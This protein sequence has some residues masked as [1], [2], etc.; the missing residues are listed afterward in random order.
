MTHRAVW[1]Q[2]AAVLAGVAIVAV[3]GLRLLLTPASGTVLVLL[4]ARQP[5]HV[6]GVPVE[7]HSS[8][9]WVGLGRISD[10]SVPA[11]PETAQVAQASVPAAEYDA[12]R[13]GGEVLPARFRV[14]RGLVAPILVTI[15]SGRP[16]PAGIYAGSEGVSLGLNELAGQLRAVPAFNLV[17]QFGRPFTNASI[18]GHEVLLAA[19]HTSCHE[20]CPLYTGLFLQLR[21][22]LPPA[23][24]LV[25]ATT[26]PEEDTPE[27]L[28][29]YAGRVGASWAFVTGDARAL[30]EFWKPF[31]VE[32][33]SGDVHR[34]MLALIDAHGYIRT[35]Y[36]GTPDVGGSL[37]S[38]LQGQLNPEGLELLRSHGN[39]WGRTQV[40][41]TLRTIGSLAPASSAG[42]GSAPSFT[43]STLDGQGV[44]LNDFRGRPVII[45]FWASY[46]TPCRA[47]MPLIE[48]T[49][50]QHPKLKVLLIDER[51]DLAAAR[52]LVSELQLHSTV[53][54]DPDGRVG[55]QYGMTGLPTTIFVRGDGSVEGRYVGQMP[56]S[57]LRSHISSLGA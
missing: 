27:V 3:L 37:P 1:I 28:R 14:Q 40:T 35:F 55:D 50:Q 5:D 24:L 26:N 57:V 10:H 11:A 18:A 6:S 46:C 23:V 20:T 19:F 39:G 16:L 17:D 51:D 31:D 30:A 47:E 25:E 4:S 41:D 2:T 29:Q 9:G 43:L 21:R 38:V 53:L 56:E 44:S 33:S 22:E 48:R 49:A 54:Y 34:S 13:F 45:N 7:L 42:E 52:R 36:L 32:L 8:G 15:A 12:L